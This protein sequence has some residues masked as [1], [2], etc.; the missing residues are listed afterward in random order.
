[1]FRFCTFSL[2]PL[3]SPRRTRPCPL[4]PHPARLRSAEMFWTPAL[5]LQ[6]EDRVNRIGQRCACHIIYLLGEGTVDDLLWP[7]VRPGAPALAR[8]IS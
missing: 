8:D 6:A 2:L 3:T 1:M 7:M 4:T 5:L